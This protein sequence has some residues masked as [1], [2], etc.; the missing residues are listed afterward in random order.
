MKATYLVALVAA[1][2][3]TPSGQPQQS[4]SP[5]PPQAQEPYVPSGAVSSIPTM[6]KEYAF[7]IP[8][9]LQVTPS[10]PATPFVPVPTFA[11][12]TPAQVSA[13]LAALPS[14][15]KPPTPPGKP[16]FPGLQKKIDDAIRSA[17]GD[18]VAMREEGM[19]AS[20][21]QYRD[22]LQAY[23]QKRSNCSAFVLVAPASTPPALALPVTPQPTAP[24]H[25]KP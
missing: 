2:L 19:K 1:S 25:P 22:K 13:C 11:A 24:V 8:S 20:A 18:P 7:R 5:Q 17:G 14:P 3:L 21:Q 23:N 15:P 10:Q 16:L 4:P 6:P 12:P 9:A